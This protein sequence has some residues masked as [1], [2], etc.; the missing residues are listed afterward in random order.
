MADFDFGASDE[1]VYK[2]FFEQLKESLS[3][4]LAGQDWE[5]EEDA[6]WRSRSQVVERPRVRDY[7]TVLR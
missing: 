3:Q 7:G 1:P 5:A 4:A 2:T 6:K